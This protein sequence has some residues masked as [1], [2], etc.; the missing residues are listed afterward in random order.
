VDTEE[1]D[2]CPRLGVVVQ[3]DRHRN[4]RDESREDPGL[5]SHTKYPVR[6][7]SWWSEGPP[8]KL[9]GVE[10]SKLVLFTF[11]GVSS[12]EFIHFLELNWISDINST[13]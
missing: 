8:Q 12:K 4:T 2:C 3:A 11:N 5:R 1:I 9:R 7:R 13:L 6:N 10:K